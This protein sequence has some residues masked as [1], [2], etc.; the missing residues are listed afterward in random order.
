MSLLPDVRRIVRELDP[1]QPIYAIQT[2]EEATRASVFE[3]RL[4]LILLQIFAAIAL[5]LACVGVY[6]MVSYAVSSRSKEIGIRMALG[7]DRA[8][9][10]RLVLKQSLFLVAIGTAIG[11]AGSLALGRFVE[12]LLFGTTPTDPLALLSVVM[13]LGLVALIA[14]YLPARR[15]GRLDP[16]RAL[17][18]D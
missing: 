7:A 9:V 14:G 18:M 12:S 16:A 13:L 17:R 8:G 4:T 15:A 11:L 10:I 2:L 5:S 3:Q 1:N 6:G